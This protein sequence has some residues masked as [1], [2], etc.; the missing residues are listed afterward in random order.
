MK[1]N[2]VIIGSGPAG[3]TAAIYTG[4]AKLEPLVIEGDTPGGQLMGTSEVEN[5]P[6][7]KSIQGPDLMMEMKA[8]AAACGAEFLP[9]VITAVDFSSR[10]YKL[11]TKRG[12]S[13]ETESVIIACGASH[14]KL[15]CPGEAEYWGKGVT[16]CAT[17]DAPFYKNKEVLIVGGGNT[18]MTEAD[19]LTRFAKKVTV[20][21]I[22]DQVT[23]TDPIKDRV[24]VHPQ[25]EMIYNST[26]KE[27]KGNGT[28]VSS[29]II[30]NQKTNELTKK[31]IDGVFIAIGLRPNTTLFEGQLTLDQ[32]G[33]IKVTERTCTEKEGVFVAGDVADY[34]YKQ[35]ITSS[36]DGC[37]AALDCEIFLTGK[38]TVT[39]SK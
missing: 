28:R 32:Y 38:I 7:V 4:R 26:V 29:V 20:V 36:G 23:A 19:Y 12:K 25:I 21:H 34:R 35:A 39:Y 16:V 17:C 11:T 6:G 22:L 18:A 33:Y 37:K 15:G 10:P 2:V 31:P 9:D 1:K 27:I 24:L 5:W 30:E 3:L 14:K 13:I 8:H